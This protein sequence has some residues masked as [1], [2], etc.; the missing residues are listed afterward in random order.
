MNMRRVPLFA[1]SVLVTCLG[2][3]L[4]LPVAFGTMIYLYISHRYNRTAVW[5]QSGHSSSTSGSR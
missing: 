2:L 5:R 3:V 1:W 4:M